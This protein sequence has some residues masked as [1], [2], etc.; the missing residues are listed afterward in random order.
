M[1]WALRRSVGKFSPVG[2]PLLRM[3]VVCCTLAAVKGLICLVSEATCR[4]GGD[5]DGVYGVA[6]VALGIPGRTW[7]GFSRQV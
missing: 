4:L 7:F 6:F 1:F 5:Q 3:L 2:F